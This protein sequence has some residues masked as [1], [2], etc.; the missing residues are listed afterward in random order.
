MNDII[1]HVPVGKPYYRVMRPDITNANGQ[2][3]SNVRIF[4]GYSQRF[5]TGHE[6]EVQAQTDNSSTNWYALRIN[7]WID[8]R[9]YDPAE[10]P[11]ML[12]SKLRKKLLEVKHE[13][14][15]PRCDLRVLAATL[16]KMKA[17]PA[18][19]D[20][21]TSRVTPID[22]VLPENVH[23]WRDD[24]ETM[25]QSCCTFSA[26]AKDEVEARALMILQAKAG[27]A[28]DA[29][30]LAKWLAKGQPVKRITSLRPPPSLLT[31]E[32]LI[33]GQV[34]EKAAA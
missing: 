7:A 4:V 1:P 16:K 27:D 5:S 22:K 2:G 14:N 8:V 28:G 29:E 20:D 12:A 23:A 21:R 11:A 24:W 30:Y 9:Y 26:T 17:V 10:D 19:Y 6:I 31:L 33:K 34:E 15:A 13:A 25:E 3:Y 32:S 18:V